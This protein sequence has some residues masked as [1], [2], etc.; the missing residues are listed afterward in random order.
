MNQNMAVRI[1]STGIWT[2]GVIVYCTNYYDMG[3]FFMLSAIFI[4]CL[5]KQ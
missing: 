5:L 4:M 3:Y 2:I 1:L